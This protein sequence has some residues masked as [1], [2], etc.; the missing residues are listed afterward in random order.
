[1]ACVWDGFYL[2]GLQT[3]LHL[4]P[5]DTRDV[6]L[7]GSN[8]EFLDALATLALDPKWT[9]CIL[10]AYE[11]LMVD[12][13]NRWLSGRLQ[14][15]SR[16]KV[17][18]AL[19][20]IM[21][22]APQLSLYTEEAVF[23]WKYC[24][25]QSVM[26]EEELN[27]LNMSD[28]QLLCFL[29]ALTR[30]LEYNN[31]TYAPIVHPSKMQHLLS[32]GT[33]SVR[34]LAVKILCLYLHTSDKA[35]NE[36]RQRFVRDVEVPGSWD[37][38][39]IDYLFYPAWEIRRRKTT[40]DGLCQRR[41]TRFEPFQVP[42]QS[43]RLLET[44][45]FSPST[46]TIANIL[47]PHVGQNAREHLN[48]V[49][50]DGTTRS[51]RAVVSS[52][53]SP[54]PTL[55]VGPPGSG[56]SSII[57]DIARVL[58][59]ESKMLTLH[60]NEQTDAKYLIGLHTAS[61]MLGSFSWQPGLLTK[62]VQEGRWVLIEDIDHAPRDVM[63]LLLPLVERNELLVP[64]LGGYI[65]A[66]R[67]F[68][69]LATV[70]IDYISSPKF[71]H[72]SQNLLE[73][74]SWHQVKLE[75]LRD[76][77]IQEIISIKHPVLLEYQPMIMAVHRNLRSLKLGSFDGRNTIEIF[78]IT[79]GVTNLFRFCRRLETLLKEAGVTSGREPISE[80]VH[81]C[82]FLEAVD[83]FVSGIQSNESRRE[84]IELIAQHIQVSPTRVRYCIMSR[85]P[86]L[87]DGTTI[88][89]VGRVSLQK[90][91][92][93]QLPKPLRRGRP[94]VRTKH[95]IR[96][97]ESIAAAVKMREPC[98]LVGETGTGKTTLV[99]ELASLLGNTLTVINLSQ[100]SEASDL[101]GGFKPLSLRAL[102]APIKD[103]FELLF[104]E[105]F[106]SHENQRF[107]TAVDQAVVR[108]EWNR[109][110]KLLQ[111]VLE[112]VDNALNSRK[113]KQES[114]EEIEPPR[115]RNKTSTKLDDLTERWKIL[116]ENL[117][118]F[119]QSIEHGSKGFAF[120]FL[121][122]NLVKAVREGAWVLLDEINLASLDV[123]ESLTDLFSND[124]DGPFILLSETGK[125]ERIKAHPNFRIFGAMNPASNV[126]KRDLPPAI[127][128]RFM[129]LH[130]ESPDRD[131]DSLIQIVSSYLGDLLH[132]D[133]H[134]AQDVGNLYL[135]IKTLEGTNSL[136]DGAGQMPHF[137]LRTLT[138]TLVYVTEIASTYGL[139][140]ALFEGFAMSFLTVLNE[141]SK[142][143][144]VPL[145]EKGLF[146]QG[147][148][149]PLRLQV[150]RIPND[151]RSYIR[152]KHHWIPKGPFDVKE[153]PQ[154]IV[155]PFVGRNLLNL[156]R[157]TSARKY[158]VLLQGPTSSG[159]TSMVEYLA[160][161]SGNK[162]VRINNHEHTD[163]QE[164][165]GSYVSEESGRI[166]YREGVLVHALRQGYWVILDELNLAS[167]DI[168]EALNRLLDDNR[169]LLIPE[170]QEVV[171]PHEN[172]MLF[173]TQN[174]PGLYGGR[175]ALS[176]AFR[177]R[178]LELHFS[179]IPEQELETILRERTQIAPSFC[180]KIVSVY[181]KLAILRQSERLFEQEQSFVTLRDLFRWANR[182][183]EN[184][185]ELAIHGFM[186]LGERVRNIEERLT[187]K[188]VIQD[189]IKTKVDEERL[190]N[191]SSAVQASSTFVWTAS[192]CRLFVLV[193]EAMRR[194][195]PILLIGETGTGKTAVCQAI[196]QSMYTRLH[197]L[198]AHQNTETGDLI[199]AQR[200]IRNRSQLEDLLY[201]DMKT[202]FTHFLHRNDAAFNRSSMIRVYQSLSQ[203]ELDLLPFETRRRIDE[204][205]SKINALFEWSNSNLVQAMMN[206]EH[207]LLDEI[208]LADDA[209]LERLNSIL[210]PS[211]TLFLA[212]KGGGEAVT[213]IQGF[214][215]LATMNPSGDYGKRELSPA[216]RNRFTEIWVPRLSMG[217][218]VRKIV[219]AKLAPT[220]AEFAEPMVM[221]SL[222]FSETYNGSLFSLRQIL[223]W[224]D[225]MNSLPFS[226]PF[227][228]TVHGAAMVFI[229]GLGAN[230]SGK[231]SLVQSS[232][233]TERLKC[234]LK[235]SQL[236]DRDLTSLYFEKGIVEVRNR[237]LCIGPF[238]L[239]R[240]PH[241][242]QDITFNL[243]TPTSFANT[244]RIARALHLGKPLLIEGSPGV[245]KTTLV[246]VLAQLV[247]IPLT[248]IN[249][250]EQ[251][252]IMDLFGS[253]VPAEDAAPG[254]FVWRDAPFLQAMQ[255]GEWVLLDEMNLASQAV[256][257]GLNA[258]LD[259]RG[260][261]Y[262]P[263]LDQ[264]FSRHPSFMVF[265]AQNPHSHGNGRKGLPASFVNRF[266]VVYA[267]LL[268]DEDLRL[269]C[270][271][272]Y[273]K[274]E[275]ASINSLIGFISEFNRNVGKQQSI[276]NIAGFVE[277][278]L[279]DL[280]RWL[281]LMTSENTAGLGGDATDFVDMLF[282]HKL[283]VDQEFINI[284]RLEM[285][286]QLMLE[287]RA[288]HTRFIHL[289]PSAFQVGLALVDRQAMSSQISPDLLPLRN[290]PE[291]HNL[292]LLES[293]MIG[294]QHKWPCLLVGQKDSGKLATLTILAHKIGAFLMELPMNSDMDTMDLIGGYEQT[295]LSRRSI[296]FINKVG[297]TARRLIAEHV[298]SSSDVK[299]ILPTFAI[300]EWCTLSG[301]KDLHVLRRLLDEARDG[302][303]RE[304]T[305]ARLL[306]EC[307]GL[308]KE[309][310]KVGQAHFEWV[311][312]V[313]V[314]ALQEG[315]WIVLRDANF[316]NS[317][318]LDRLN[319]LMEPGGTLA[320]TE[321]RL[322]DGT[323]RVIQPHPK[324]RLFLTTDP[325]YGEL[326]RAMRNR[327]VELYFPPVKFVL[328]SPLYTS[329]DSLLFRYLNFQNIDWNSLKA[330]LV[331]G[332]LLVCLDH[333]SFSDIKIY[334]QFGEQLR[335]GLLSLDAT[336]LE[337]FSDVWSLFS[338]V[339]SENSLICSAIKKL[340]QSLVVTWP[341]LEDVLSTQVRQ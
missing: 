1:M 155:T 281:Q 143:A 38:V 180:S 49:L 97:C 221:F 329:S 140:R 240:Y 64:N 156:V 321:N 285:R 101:L 188:R 76:S 161:I 98:L 32:H 299:H 170:T 88:C 338:R 277:Y 194:N 82:M 116:R 226:D 189:V 301:P 39:T 73:T 303:A 340:Y 243:N 290:K 315:H 270:T 288:Y 168:L 256:L 42:P 284:S 92:T 167:S 314:R 157:A 223:T 95:A 336:K 330:T 206:G 68:K 78:Q 174:P 56:K 220:V 169:E 181:K 26:P 149:K 334:Q 22:F 10:V 125:I 41:T 31:A 335:S 246:K 74:D 254:R 332:V 52:I 120:Y 327:C 318:V 319:A 275:K 121:E 278:N 54:K 325:K 227:L 53:I 230:P 176:R 316:C 258:C 195:E 36:M 67:G 322:P 297:E 202:M 102:A 57:K 328:T 158:P 138:R 276:F 313:L 152:F 142:N 266:T 283:R 262:I 173:A 15:A 83:S 124:A 99:Q 160:S 185:E 175:K 8:C 11:P 179:D 233:I 172:F 33:A 305:Y 87:V 46:L 271:Q 110:A 96:S 86:K 5:L 117:H 218:D 228:S 190:Y 287:Q 111:G 34:Y 201:R 259:H 216:L 24:H 208:S 63:S 242:Y 123:L 296:H 65:R 134:A 182:K 94:F 133:R 91:Q 214:Q 205:I 28:A 184:R 132:G 104:N 294:V 30:L 222:W 85:T 12:I 127:R 244:L 234:L 51:I 268:T 249:L 264:T 145:I 235:L 58:C 151:G 105:T 147:D 263:E 112:R 60:L 62:A 40:H 237:S 232:I 300:V 274:R 115:K 108:K 211:R 150:P 44:K 118:I 191:V 187:V 215:F 304:I 293:L 231:V 241:S 166:V 9:A 18:A 192:M 250:S 225:F 224:V 238:Q 37:A 21:P 197:T 199:G 16:L 229:D 71:S 135:G 337:L 252:D 126:G 77:D 209:V 213:A 257:E 295:D 217:P 89:S 128:S 79:Q 326:S 20:S 203:S 70:R 106:P 333:L 260:Q 273:P 309:Q 50:S 48:L 267:D 75:S 291:G 69:L 171:R 146:G 307:S 212:E 27:L 103:D 122:G 245:G 247:G 93:P 261:V 341:T 196:A 248:R 311:D 280:L 130:I 153:Q 193:T 35:F 255:R 139:R 163:L 251:T 164:Y 204:Y 3:S 6:L 61:G 306:D 113:R 289:S 17:V 154:Y 114:S 25:A 119:Q 4:L 59:Q 109:L 129:E 282:L 29:L 13:C 310:S 148:S 80:S 339:L 186:I 55:V 219:E 90:C 239:A 162:C 107:L 200:P 302:S 183:A 72:L 136:V 2:E 236:F 165:L 47:L 144:V 131:I 198:N 141:E 137:S 19:A 81:D 331:R 14:V 317:S 265:A 207:F 100:Q 7:H 269:I 66:A 159:K 23:R 308:L 43:A 312:G 286:Q 178:F 177:N 45:D 298:S 320:I 324:F 253:D 323:H 272:L 84:L 279:R 210:E 292:A